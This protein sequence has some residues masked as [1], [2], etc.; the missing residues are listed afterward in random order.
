MKNEKHLC[1]NIDLNASGVQPLE[2]HCVT[3]EEQKEWKTK[4]N[5]L[6]G[7]KKY[8]VSGKTVTH[9]SGAYIEALATWE[10]T[11]AVTDGHVSKRYRLLKFYHL[12]AC[13]HFAIPITM[14]DSHPALPGLELSKKERDLL[15]KIATE[16][17]T[18]KSRM[19]TAIVVKRNEKQEVK[20]NRNQACKLQPNEEVVANL[21]NQ[22]HW[23]LTVMAEV[24]LA[25][26]RP[27]TPT[28]L[29]PRYPTAFVVT[30]GSTDVFYQA[31]S[32]LNLTGTDVPVLDI[33]TLDDL[34]DWQAYGSKLTLI[35]AD[36]KMRKKLLKLGRKQLFVGHLFLLTSKKYDDKTYYHVSVPTNLAPLTEEQQDACRA[37]MA[38][39][40]D[41]PK[42]LAERVVGDYDKIMESPISYRV[43]ESAAWH[44]V[45]EIVISE[46]LLEHC[47]AVK[48]AQ[49]QRQIQE[50]KSEQM[51]EEAVALVLDPKQYLDG[52]ATEWPADEAGVN[53]LLQ[54]YYALYK[55]ASKGGAKF[56]AF[57]VESLMALCHNKIE[58]PQ[59]NIDLVIGRLRARGAIKER[60]TST[61]L[62]RGKNLRM[63]RINAEDCESFSLTP[64]TPNKEASADVS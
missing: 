17:L 40:L 46:G 13:I 60:K 31:L 5:E 62:S 47:E 39:L 49:D 51:L 52:I 43:Q 57:T 28:P 41:A 33:V 36:R 56:L 25:N 11:V 3:A 21:L 4:R 44:Q 27:W 8:T 58:L 37:F 42:K 29:L 22:N 6:K 53:A 16:L 30:G 14:A 19:E 45:V 55:E 9:S 23:I 50:Q 34:A 2:Y 59:E 26:I 48:T 12:N 1:K 61:Y 63:I 38:K 64:L 20:E 7:A 18:W 35:N 54:D 24:M 15:Y 10:G 32:A